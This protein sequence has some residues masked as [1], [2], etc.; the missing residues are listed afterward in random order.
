MNTAWATALSVEALRPDHWRVACRLADGR[1]APA[2]AYPALCGPIAPGDRLL[3]NTTAV[4][5]GLGT[6]GAH[7]VIANLSGAAGGSAAPG[8][9][10]KMRYTPLQTAVLAVEEDA[11]PWRETL[12]EA[13]TLDGMPVVCCELL[14]QAPAVLAGCGLG[15]PAPRVALVMT[16][17]AALPAPYSDAIAELRAG[18]R[19]AAVLTAGQA[20][21]GDFEAVSVYSGLLAARWAVGAEVAVVSPGPGT[22]GTGARWGFGGVAQAEALNAV[23]ALGGRAIGVVRASAADPRPRHRGISHHTHTVFTR[24]ALGRFAA[25]WPAGSG[26]AFTEDWERLKKGTEG[27]MEPFEIQGAAEAL[28]ALASDAPLL[29]SMG[30]GRSEDPLFF[31]AAA[32]AGLLARRWARERTEP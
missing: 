30:R 19:L 16:D 13:D 11:S 17:E 1:E 9:I 2:I 4:D 29:R 20:F 32:A 31:E 25:A 14:S 5:L 23:H 18:G 27:R 22:V 21:G 10:V 6:G 3:L 8:H 15:A 12:R 7:F 28:D 24:A 26:A